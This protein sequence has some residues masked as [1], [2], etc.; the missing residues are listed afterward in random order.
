[1]VEFHDDFGCWMLG[2]RLRFSF[3]SFFCGG[4]MLVGPAK[5]WVVFEEEVFLWQA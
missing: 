2:L 5:A 3:F 1:M 4:L